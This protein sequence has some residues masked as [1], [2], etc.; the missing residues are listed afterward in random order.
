[1]E[2]SRGCL[3]HDGRFR[4]FNRETVPGT[5]FRVPNFR[6][7]PASGDECRSKIC[8]EVRRACGKGSHTQ[9]GQ[10]T[11]FQ[12]GRGRIL[13]ISPLALSRFAPSWSVEMTDDPVFAGLHHPRFV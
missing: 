6:R 8:I 11:S 5:A 9:F 2:R 12:H 3:R 1:V 10:N 13:G 7:G 4:E